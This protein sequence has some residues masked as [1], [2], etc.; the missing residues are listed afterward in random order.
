M[1]QDQERY[2]N[3]EVG[4]REIHLREGKVPDKAFMPAGCG[5]T[6]VQT[7]AELIPLY[8]LYPE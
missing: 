2:S 3:F 6:K 4:Y 7:K 1:A 5:Q 8:T